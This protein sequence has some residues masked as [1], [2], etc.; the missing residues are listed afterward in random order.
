[1]DVEILSC[2]SGAREARGISV[3]IDVF[4]ASN[5]ILACLGRGAECVIPVCSL[6]DARGLKKKN[7]R[8]LLFGER[9]GL[10]PDGVDYGNSPVLASKLRLKGKRVILTTSAGTQGILG[11]GKSDEV[12][13]GS[14]ANACA[15]V[16]YITKRNLLKVSL[17]AIGLEAHSACVEDELCAEYI[18]GRLLGKFPD[19]EGVKREILRSDGANRL[20]RLKQDDDLDFCLKLDV[21][22]IVPRFDFESGCLSVG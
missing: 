5:T 13:V 14:F 7:P 3:I 8:S 21:Y 15:V 2:L 11:A 1:M 6:D 12:I 19:F 10:V 16:D 18:R 17:V 22:D 4:R 20:R 9:K